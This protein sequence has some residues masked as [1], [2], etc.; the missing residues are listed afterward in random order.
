[1][2]LN[3]IHPLGRREKRERKRR[4]LWMELSRVHKSVFV[5]ILSLP[6]SSRVPPWK[7]GGKGKKPPPRKI[8]WREREKKT[9]RLW[10]RERSGNWRKIRREGSVLSDAKDV[11]CP[12]PTWE[13]AWERSER[14]F[15]LCKVFFH[16]SG[17]RKVTAT[18]VRWVV[19]V[20]CPTTLSQQKVVKK[21][22]YRK[23]SS[24]QRN[25]CSH[26]ITK[27]EVL[28][29]KIFDVCSSIQGPFEKSKRR[30]EEHDNNR[31][32]KKER[33]WTVKIQPFSPPP[34]SQWY[35]RSLPPSPDKDDDEAIVLPTNQ[36]KREEGLYKR[37]AWVNATFGAWNISI[38]T[39]DTQ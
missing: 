29:K 30:E 39:S 12:L 33:R 17:G 37:E 7:E 23:Y 35:G 21:M 3:E 16:L 22:L 15:L 9:D 5:G 1:M 10:E 20:S 14:I 31:Q 6:F 18:F 27:L 8:G 11:F 28:K 34:S 32:V 25:F 38:K 26:S 13:G 36:G 4:N 24:T 19:S 2:F